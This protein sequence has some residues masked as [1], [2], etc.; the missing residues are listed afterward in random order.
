M[1]V[2]GQLVGVANTQ[3]QPFLPG[4][5]G[6]LQANRQTQSIEAAGHRQRGQSSEVER[7]GESR[8]LRQHGVAADTGGGHRLRRRHEHIR[9]VERRPHLGA[10]R[11]ARSLGR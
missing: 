10:E 11:F 3:E 8:Q 4:R 2:G 6:K 1:P 7:I 9:L 5:R